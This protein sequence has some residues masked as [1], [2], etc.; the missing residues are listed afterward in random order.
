MTAIN[1]E[2]EPGDTRACMLAA[3]AARGD[4][5]GVRRILT[6]DPGA[7]NELGLDGTSPLCAATLWGYT[8]ILRLLLDSMA[9][10]GIRNDSGPQWTPLHAAALQEDGKACMLLLD[11]QANPLEPDNEGVTPCDYASVSEAVWPIFAA[12]GCDKVPKAELVNKGVLRRASSALEAQLMREAEGGD[13]SRRGLIN[14]Y[15]RPGSAYV[16]SR[17]FPPRPGSSAGYRPPG[18]SRP[19]ETARK[20]PSRPIDILEEEEPGPSPTMSASMRSGGL[21]SLGI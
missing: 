10:P 5:A 2:P 17:E 7:V 13:Q 6:A 11:Y 3:F 15:S 18:T 21:R 19:I 9:S 20:N 1:V 16:V 12:R 8:D 4:E 14:E